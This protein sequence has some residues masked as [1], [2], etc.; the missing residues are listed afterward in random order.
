M[1][2]TSAVGSVG[3]T[4][5]FTCLKTPPRGSFKINLRKD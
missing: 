1:N 2:A 5:R 3:L 4:N